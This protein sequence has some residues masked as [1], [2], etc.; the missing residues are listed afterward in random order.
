EN[1]PLRIPGRPLSG[2]QAPRGRAPADLH[3]RP[4]GAGGQAAHPPVAEP[5]ANPHQE[6]APRRE[7][8]RRGRRQMKTPV[9]QRLPAGLL[10]TAA[11]LPAAAAARAQPP[12]ARSG[13]VIPRDVREMY[14]RGLQYLASSQSEKGDWSG[15]GTEGPRGEVGPGPTGLAL[16]AF[17]AS[18]EDPN[19]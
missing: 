5:G 14:D 18:G 8:R 19:F 16:M 7:G 3:R 17:L 13:E 2:G 15:T 11:L 9:A 12:T 4:V 10:T 6:R 1:E